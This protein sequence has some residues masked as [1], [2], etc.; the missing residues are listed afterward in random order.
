MPNGGPPRP[1]AWAAVL[2]SALGFWV[3]MNYRPP[4]KEL[5][6]MDFMNNYL[7]Q[8]KVKEIKI[9]KDRNSEVFNH[10]ADIELNDGD[11]YYMILGNQE[12]F[13]AK[14]DHI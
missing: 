8:N 10:R 3:V 13:L 4:K 1:E 2:A 7:M 6:M 12:S 5:V 14:L 9:S 11:Q